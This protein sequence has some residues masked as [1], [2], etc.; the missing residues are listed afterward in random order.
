VA[1]ELDLPLEL[2]SIDMQKGEHKKPD[3]LKFNPNGKVP[4]LKHGD[5]YL[6]E[7]NAIALYLASLRPESGLLPR[8]PKQAA[9]VDQWLFWKSSHFYPPFGRIAFERVIKGVFG[10]GTPDEAVVE[11]AIKD[12]G[13]FASVL[14]AHL[15]SRSFVV[16]DRLT[17]ADLSLACSL[18]LRGLAKFETN[19]WPHLHAWLARIEALPSYKATAPQA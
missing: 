7:S 19:K 15:A 4:V 17:L 13:Q 11:Q 16:G 6:W 9:Q 18:T 10:M 14:D 2:H 5:F 3:F 8:D 1:A 12:F